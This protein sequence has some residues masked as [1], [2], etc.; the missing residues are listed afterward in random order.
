MK[1]KQDV[2]QLLGKVEP[3]KKAKKPKEK[4]L[5]SPLSSKTKGAGGVIPSI[6]A[7]L[8]KPAPLPDILKIQVQVEYIIL[9][10]YTACNSSYRVKIAMRMSAPR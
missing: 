7:K 1:A 2:E 10:T 6:G 3:K 5:S 9:G 4:T 8:L